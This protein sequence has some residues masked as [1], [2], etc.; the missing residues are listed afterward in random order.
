ME[1]R[2]IASLII[3]AAGVAAVLV[4]WRFLTLRSQGTPVIV[5]RL[6][7]EGVHGWRHGMLRYRGMVLYY[8]KVRSILPFPNLVF[9][10][11]D[12]HVVSRRRITAGE[13]SFMEPNLSVLQLDIAGQGY[14]VALDA[15]GEMALTAWIEAAPSRQRIRSNPRVARWYFRES[16]GR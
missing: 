3:A 10:R 6:P 14:E 7:A 2:I 8:Y 9:S 16:Q 1:V 4:L 13:A 15:R 11:A 5:R 12:T